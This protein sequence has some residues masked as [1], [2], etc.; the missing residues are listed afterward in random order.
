MRI[1]QDV[2]RGAPLTILIDG[3][4][5]KSFLGET[6]AAAMLANG[7]AVFRK[8]RDGTPRGAFCNMGTCCECMVT[9]TGTGRRVRACLT[10]V[11]DG[12]E[13]T[14]DG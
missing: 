5:T 14:L 12:L 13:I 3:V 6:I 11:H 2:T 8:D 7:Q 1:D 10:D 4:A 9:L